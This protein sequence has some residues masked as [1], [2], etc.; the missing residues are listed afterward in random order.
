[1]A[2]PATVER[3]R[4]IP[5]FAQLDDAALTRVAEAGTDFEAESGRVLVQLREPGSGLFFIEEGTVAVD[6]KG[7]T[8]ELG[9]GEFFGELSLLVPDATRTARVRAVTRVRCFALARNP[10]LRLLEDEPPIALAMLRTLARR[11]LHEVTS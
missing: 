5:L 2:D 8:I 11:L 4:A 1:M 10:A 7:R 9:P 3:L 6:L